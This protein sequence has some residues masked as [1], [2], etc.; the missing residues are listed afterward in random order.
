M[1]CRVPGR[2]MPPI[3]MVKSAPDEVCLAPYAAPRQW[4]TQW[5]WMGLHTSHGWL[6]SAEIKCK[7]IYLTRDPVQNICSISSSGYTMGVQA[8]PVSM[9][10]LHCSKRARVQDFCIWILCDSLKNPDHFWCMFEVL[11]ICTISGHILTQYT[12]CRH[13]LNKDIW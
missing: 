7:W 11:L 5:V 12:S 4:G 10:C 3:W 13:I 6:R 2:F 1:E 8:W 9:L